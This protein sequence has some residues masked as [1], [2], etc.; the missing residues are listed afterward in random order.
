MKKKG[1]LIVVGVVAA[2][3]IGVGVAQHF[4]PGQGYLV[5]DTPGAELALHRRFSLDVGVRSD[6]RPRKIAAR[7]Y[8]P[9]SLH[10]TRTVDGDTWLLVARGPWG[11]M[12]TIKVKNDST[13]TVKPGP[14]LQVK[15][16]IRQG[17]GQVSVDLAIYGQAGERYDNVIHKNGR[18]L[19]PPLIKII[20]QDGTVLA[21]DDFEY[22]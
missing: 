18:R 22:G 11:D 17:R 21:Q 9:R 1:I 14:P 10:L 4:W 16:K 7:A 12:T 19:G 2:V 20:D 6:S 5:V 3:A 13:T 8:R 15:P